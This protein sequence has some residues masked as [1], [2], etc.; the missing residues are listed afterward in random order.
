MISPLR[1][2]RR[3]IKPHSHR[4]GRKEG[5]ADEI[6]TYPPAG[7]LGYTPGG[8]R[9]AAAGTDWTCVD[10]DAILM[11]R[12]GNLKMDLY[13]PRCGGE[14]CDHDGSGLGDHGRFGESVFAESLIDR[15]RPA[16]SAVPLTGCG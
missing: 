12:L 15:S 10:T 6:P 5:V 4:R 3:K 1:W 13:D 11:V 2:L 14:G 7:S 16:A 8:K 9:F